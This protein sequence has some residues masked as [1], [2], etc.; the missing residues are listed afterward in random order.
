MTNQ[1]IDSVPR[2]DLQEI[3][4]QMVDYWDRIDGEWGSCGMTVDEAMDKGDLPALAKLRALL[5]AEPATCAES[6]VE[7]TAQP[8][9]PAY[10][11]RLCHIDYTA[12]PYI[13]GCLKGDEEAQRRF[14]ERHGKSG[15][16]PKPQGEPLIHI[17]PEVLAMLRGERKMQPGGLTY[18]ESK[19]LGDWTVPLYVGQPASVAGLEKR[20]E[21]L[22][23]QAWTV[24][25]EAMDGA[26]VHP[27][28][29]HSEDAKVRTLAPMYQALYASLKAT[30]EQVPL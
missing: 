27:C 12:H 18:S 28:D 10:P 19:P 23:E 8:D 9:A 1:T 6:Q 22:R 24:M 11:N 29:E 15:A 14:D 13:C 2:A 25:Q 7:A 4:D 3:Y 16:D 21:R 5:N 26:R 17:T 20:Y 30:D